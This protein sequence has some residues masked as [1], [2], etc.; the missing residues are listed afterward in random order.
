[1]PEANYI[2][3]N[4]VADIITVT[5]RPYISKMD[6]AKILGACPTLSFPRLTI[7][8][9][10][11]EKKKKDIMIGNVAYSTLIQNQLRLA[12]TLIIN[13]KSL[14]EHYSKL[15]IVRTLCCL[16]IVF[17]DEFQSNSVKS[18]SFTINLAPRSIL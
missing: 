15:V 8:I 6:G 17:H 7:I 5:I 11:I 4:T 3:V 2:N 9:G 10:K 18:K 1:M 13:H 14:K 12:G 16:M